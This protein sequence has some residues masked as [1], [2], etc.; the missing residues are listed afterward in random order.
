MSTIPRIWTLSRV[1]NILFPTDFSDRSKHAR[2]YVRALAKELGATV[3]VLHVIDTSAH[4]EDQPYETELQRRPGRSAQDEVESQV[5]EIARAIE[6]AGTKVERHWREG[7]VRVETLRL[8]DNLKIDLVVMATHARLKLDVTVLGSKY[9]EIIRDADVPVLA[10]KYREREFVVE[11]EETLAIKR[12]LCPCDLTAFSQQAVPIAADICRHFKAEL[13]FAHLVRSEEEMLAF[14]GFTEPPASMVPYETLEHL[15]KAYGDIPTRIV[16]V[17]GK[18]Q[19][20]LAEVCRFEDVDL[21][22]MATHGRKTLARNIVGSVAERLV[23][24]VQCPIMTIRPELIA[25]R[26]PA[27]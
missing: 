11:P 23:V 19:K 4:W 18:P 17:K 9:L 10:I 13:V 15:A 2:P 14:H 1:K 21:V 20:D 3:H 22:V 24:D 27:S 5:D 26:F 16:G 12:V 25:K 7:D 6:V 8:I